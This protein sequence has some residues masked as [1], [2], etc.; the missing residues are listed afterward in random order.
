MKAAVGYEWEYNSVID[1]LIV[2]TTQANA[3]AFGGLQHLQRTWDSVYGELF[4]PLVGPDNNVPLVARSIS[5]PAVRYTDYEVVGST[6]NP[7]IGVNWTLND[8]LKLHAS[9]GTSFRAPQLSELVGPVTG[10]F[11][12]TYATPNGPVLGY[13]LGRRQPQPEARD[14]DDLVARRRLDAVLR[15][16]SARCRSTTSTSTTP[17]RS[18]AIS[19]T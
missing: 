16:A 9:W 2:G 18:P 17:T 10:V 6:T 14:G 1:G 19:A 8:Q 13:T 4:V 11:Y 12:Q 15:A 5:T 7:K 3:P